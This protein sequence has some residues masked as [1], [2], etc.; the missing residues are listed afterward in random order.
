MLSK[1]GYQFEPTSHKIIA[2]AIKVHKKLG[3][4]FEEVIYQRSLAQELTMANL[5]FGREQWIDVF[6]EDRK[7]G[8]KRVDFLIENILVEI[9]AKAYYDPQDYMQTLSYL[10]ATQLKTALLINF[11]SKIINIKRMVNTNRLSPFP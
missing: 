4:G 10:K 5:R 11:G 1:N 7:I 8:R 2:L 6:Y 9:K 3:P